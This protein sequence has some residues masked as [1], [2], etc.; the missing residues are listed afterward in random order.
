MYQQLIQMERL[1]C[2]SCH[3]V[4]EAGALSGP[5]AEVINFQYTAQRL[6][7]HYFERYVLDPQRALPGTMMPKY[8]DEEFQSP[9][10]DIFDGD[11]RRQFEAIW[12]HM[13]VLSDEFLKRTADSGPESPRS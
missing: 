2:I 10:K 3:A 5:T 7:K 8:P 11:A 4:G 12:Q 13:R 1:G 6:R 9:I